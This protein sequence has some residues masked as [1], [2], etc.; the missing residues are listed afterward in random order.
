VLRDFK[1]ER[2]AVVAGL[3]AFKMAGSPPSN[4]TSTTGPR[5]WVILPVR[6][7]FHFPLFKIETLKGFCAGDDFDQL[8]GDMA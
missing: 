4:V 1:H 5:T 2:L 3:S 6:V 8:L 7:H